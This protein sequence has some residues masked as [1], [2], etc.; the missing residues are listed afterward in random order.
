MRQLSQ[1]LVITSFYSSVDIEHSPDLETTWK[2]FLKM[3]SIVFAMFVLLLVCL[4]DHMV[5]AGGKG[6]TIII[7][8]G[9]GGG[10]SY[11]LST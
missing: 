6:D 8:G 1:A 3:K 5:Q 2:H 7:G 11:N 10:G 9:G 4:L